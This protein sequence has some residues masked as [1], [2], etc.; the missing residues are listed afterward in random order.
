MG[1]IRKFTAKIF[2]IN[3][4]T[5]SWFYQNSIVVSRE[6]KNLLDNYGR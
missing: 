5:E 1:Y 2:L 3:S 6:L 4:R